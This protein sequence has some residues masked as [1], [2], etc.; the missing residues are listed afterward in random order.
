[1][2]SGYGSMLSSKGRRFD[3]RHRILD[4]HFSHIL[5]IFCKNCNDVRLKRSK[6]NN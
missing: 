5:P 3:S 6:I 4:G 2:F 1:M